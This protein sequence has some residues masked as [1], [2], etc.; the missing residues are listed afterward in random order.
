MSIDP[1]AFGDNIS[2]V[3]ADI[4]LTDITQLPI[5]VIPTQQLSPSEVRYTT[6][7][8]LKTDNVERYTNI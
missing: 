2:E 5:T 1:N 7:M 6:Y 8:L 4:D 3:D